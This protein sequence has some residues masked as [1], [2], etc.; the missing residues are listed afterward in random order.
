MMGPPPYIHNRGYC[1]AHPVDGTVVAEVTSVL[2][3][4]DGVLGPPAADLTEGAVGV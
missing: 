1:S 4:S 3:L 2:A